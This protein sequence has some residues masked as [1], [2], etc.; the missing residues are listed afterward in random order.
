MPNAY[1]YKVLGGK[2]RQLLAIIAYVFMD[3]R[4]KATRSRPKPKGKGKPGSKTAKKGK[5]KPNEKK[6]SKKGDKKKE[7]KKKPGKDSEGNA[8]DG[9]E[10]AGGEPGGADENEGPEDEKPGTGAEA[11]NREEVSKTEDESGT[12]RMTEM[13]ERKKQARFRSDEIN[14]KITSEKLKVG[15]VL[16]P[17]E[18]KNFKD[19]HGDQ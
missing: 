12:Q 1:R 14:V 17:Q 18:L 8:G 15:Y 5:K 19:M 9:E 3:W 2:V 13:T 16:D 11:Q 4:K 6:D 7:K 10:H